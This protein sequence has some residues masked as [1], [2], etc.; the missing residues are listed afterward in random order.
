YIY[1]YKRCFAECVFVESQRN[2]LTDPVIVWLTGGPGC[3]GLS[4]LLTENGP[5][6]V[7]PDG[8]S[9]VNNPYSWNRIANVLTLESPVGVGFSYTDDGKLETDDAKVASDNWSAL[10]EFF[11]AFPQFRKN[12]FYIAGESYGGIYVPTLAEAVHSG[13]KNFNI[14]LKGLLIGN[15]CV[16][17]K[18]NTNTMI[19]YGYNHGMIDEMLLS[20]YQKLMVFFFRISGINPY[21]IYGTCYHEGSLKLKSYLAL[22]KAKIDLLRKIKRRL[23]DSVSKSQKKKTIYLN[24]PEVRKALFIPSNVI[25][26]ADCSDEV[27]DS[28]NKIYN[29]MDSRVKSAVGNGSR[30]LIYN[31][32][33]DLVC[34][35]LQGQRFA[36]SLG[37]KVSKAIDEAKTSKQFSF[38]IDLFLFYKEQGDSV[39]N[40]KV[41]AS[42]FEKE[43]KLSLDRN[44][45]V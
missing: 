31:G 26:W 10:K 25:A 32:D 1:I 9:L 42:Q 13:Q 23:P 30:V 36:A 40:K 20:F 28:Y 43:N 38:L 2:P 11:T 24:K 7:Q 39:F 34:N 27:Y 14:N 41:K 29:E 22:S 21:D 16:S 37:Y 12:D 44:E 35:F 5:F 17:E 4:A 19:Q 45:T 33:T 15:G 8:Q 6:T 3:S 18:I